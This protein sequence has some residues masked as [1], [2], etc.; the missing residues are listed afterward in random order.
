MKR[1]SRNIF[2]MNTI[3]PVYLE[4]TYHVQ[5]RS[6]QDKNKNNPSSQT[7][8]HM[9]ISPPS[10]YIAKVYVILSDIL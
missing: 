10:P 2:N 6:Q 8:S 5:A 1:F 7:R 3:H 9:Q 4:N